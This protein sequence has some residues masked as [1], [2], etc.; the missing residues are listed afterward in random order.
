M[1]TVSHIAA[2]VC[3][4][5]SVTLFI[6]VGHHGLG[7]HLCTLGLT[8]EMI[9]FIKHVLPESGAKNNEELINYLRSASQS[10]LKSA[11]GSLELAEDLEK[12]LPD[13]AEFLQL[14]YGCSTCYQLALTFQKVSIALSLLAMFGFNRPFLVKF[15]RRL[16]IVTGL[17]FLITLGLGFFGT[18]PA[19]A[20]WDI[21]TPRLWSIPASIVYTVTAAANVLLDIGLGWI[22]LY[23]V[24]Q[25]QLS[26]KDRWAVIGLGLSQWLSIIFGAARC[27]L[28][29][30]LF[31]ED[32]TCK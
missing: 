23:Y 5:V 4:I 7:T 27:F 29:A 21:S 10:S 6:V 19:S 14:L 26:T 20:S 1:Y 3:A 18:W 9:T 30:G 31:G 28:L 2:V 17:V 12:F 24:G 32:L 25:T 22:P 11:Q 8:E 16:F 15:V 13:V